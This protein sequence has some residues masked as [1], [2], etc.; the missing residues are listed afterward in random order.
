MDNNDI[1]LSSYPEGWEYA[2]SLL[3]IP[4][5]EKEAFMIRYINFILT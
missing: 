5:E 3:E 2:K 4:K 1:L